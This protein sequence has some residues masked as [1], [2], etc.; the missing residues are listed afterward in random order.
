[1]K[2]IYQLKRLL[3]LLWRFLT[4]G[5]NSFGQLILETLH[6]LIK[7]W[8]RLCILLAIA[9]IAYWAYKDTHTEH[10]YH[11]FLEFIGVSVTFV[12]VEHS[13]RNLKSGIEDPIGLPVKKFIKDLKDANRQL[14]IFDTFLET[15]LLDEKE[16]N[17][18]A[19]R[20]SLIHVLAHNEKF[21]LK[22]LLINSESPYVKTRAEQRGEFLGEEHKKRIERAMEKLVDILSQIIHKYPKC[23]DKIEIKEYTETPPF[24]IY[25][26]DGKAY[27]SFYPE[28]MKTSD[29]RQLYIPNDTDLGKQL[30]AFFMAKFDEVWKGAVKVT[31]KVG[32]EKR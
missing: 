10:Y 25:A 27:V 6:T 11:V 17:H 19:F 24:A 5:D 22:I 28:G 14:I 20:S 2:L 15:L 3:R 23:A 8:P 32:R 18:N 26:V 29:A 13:I 31:I 21:R 4:K 1:M 12:I 9:G 16:V 30:F 7:E